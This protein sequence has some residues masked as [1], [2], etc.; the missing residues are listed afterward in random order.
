MEISHGNIAH[1]LFL[2]DTFT[3]ACDTT[4][5]YD[6]L[7]GCNVSPHSFKDN[8][9]AAL[10][11]IHSAVAGGKSPTVT[12]HRIISPRSKTG[13]GGTILIGHPQKCSQGKKDREVDQR[14]IDLRA[15]QPS[16]NKLQ[17]SQ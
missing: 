13:G 3:V 6:T 7:L 11:A 10:P 2:A 8:M 17:A 14:R 1:L 9:A 5:I 12:Q 15:Q 4:S 16:L